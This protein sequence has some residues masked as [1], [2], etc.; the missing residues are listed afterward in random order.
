MACSTTM[1]RSVSAQLFRQK[2]S[3][4]WSKFLSGHQRMTSSVASFK[5]AD[6]QIKYSNNITEKKPDSDTLLFGHTFTDHMLT[7]EWSKNAGWQAPCIQPFGNLSMHPACSVF[8]YGL[9]LFE[10]MKAYA[11]VDDKVRMFRP[12]DNMTRMKY[13]ANKVSLP[14]FDGDELVRCIA[15]LIRVD[16]DW[17]PKTKPCS[18]YIRPTFIST[19]P[20]I[21]VSVPGK[22]LLY[23]IMCPVGPYFRTGSF[24]P[25]S[26]Y[27][28]PKNVR[29]WK[30]GAGD[31]KV[32]GN[33]GP[34]IK[35]QLDAE[36]LGCQQI[37]WLYGNEDYV[38]EVG[39][40]NLMM[41]WHND[42]GDLELITPPL[43]GTILPGVTRKALL[44][45]ARGWEEFKVTERP[46]KMD[47]VVKAVKENRVLEIFGAGTACV[48]CPVGSIL[49]KDET[50][51]IPTMENGAPYATRFF[52]TLLDI[53]YGKIPSPWVY[54]ID[55]EYDAM[56][57]KVSS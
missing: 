51:N 42:D 44:E 3:C 54:D 10:G 31:S 23:V 41:M 56:A 29:A 24:N 22:A 35:P 50:L 27:A 43:D 34:T 19:E 45:L 8:H 2:T 18:L 30:G 21:G 5:A 39:T 25:V 49:Y 40:M 17:V 28:D 57:A 33:Y 53:Q 9:E 37:L 15:Q 52:D 32:G 1:L 11:G 38:T 46:F 55:S 48:V 20:T 6:L 36:K 7:I 26:L 14:D 47:E 4:R 13:S 12:W 16:R